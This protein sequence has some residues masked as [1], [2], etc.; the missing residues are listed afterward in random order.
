MPTSISEGVSFVV[1]LNSLENKDDVSA[2]DM[3]VWKNNGVDTSYIHVTMGKSSVDLVQKCSAK[4]RKSDTYSVKRV[5]RTHATDKSLKKITAFIHGES[6][7]TI[8]IYIYIYIY[9]YVCSIDQ[10]Y[11]VHVYS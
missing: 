1:E 11:N 2:D 7:Y 6:K 10:C 4:D 8:N 5:Y 3:G 9:I